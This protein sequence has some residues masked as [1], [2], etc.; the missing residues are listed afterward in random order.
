MQASAAVPISD[1]INQARLHRKIGNSWRDEHHYEE[2][3][4]VYQETKAVLEQSPAAESADWWQEFIQTL[5]EINLLYYWLGLLQES[6][7][8]RLE[9]EPAIEQHATPAQRAAYFQSKSWTELRRNH[10]ATTPEIISLVKAALT[11]HEEIGNQAVIPAAQFGVGFALLWHGDV[12]PA[13][14]FFQTALR[15]AEET[16]DISLQARCLSYLTIAYR[17]S[18][19]LEETEQYGKRG[20]EVA[21]LANMPE[22]IAMAKA[23]QAWVAWRV[24]D[25]VLSQELGGLALHF[26]QQV[27]AGHASAPF[28]WLALFPLIA[29]A[30]Q[31]DKVLWAVD[32]ARILLDP[33]LQRLP[34]LLI[35]TLERA[36]QAWDRNEAESARTLL[37]Q[38]IALAQQ[39]HYL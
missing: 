26:W 34:D 5:L 13:K 4:R 21:T 20:L 32:N 3:L 18:E 39:M 38:S 8:L 35:T 10:F 22:Y 2:A 15:L 17:Q 1:Y 28:Q 29:L 12:E 23:N 14:D 11:I 19:H 33:I 6:D 16:G 9:L 37:H 30:L 27:P 7:Q 25:Q 31:Q 24:D 36:I